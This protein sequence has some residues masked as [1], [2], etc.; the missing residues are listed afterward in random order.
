MQTII[1]KIQELL[2]ENGIPNVDNGASILSQIDIQRAEDNAIMSDEGYEMAQGNFDKI[3][4]RIAPDIVVKVRY[5]ITA[6]GP[7]KY[8]T[9]NLQAIDAYTSEPVAVVSGT[10]GRTMSGILPLMV[11]AAVLD[12]MPDF[13]AVLNDF[14]EE[15]SEYGRKIRFRIETVRNGVLEDG[16]ETEFD[17][18]YLNEIIENWVEENS[19]NGNYS[20]PAS[21]RNR[22]T[23]NDVRI[24]L[25]NEKG[26]AIDARNWVGGLN[27]L[28]KKTYGLK[29]D[30]YPLG[31]GEFQLII[32]KK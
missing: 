2:K 10:S 14:Y 26:R 6:N 19:V 3:R 5:F 15:A 4:E 30:L 8:L 12:R 25:F 7:E 9:F 1:L 31:L 17:G 27:E 11:E 24:P 18:Q 13:V 23:F 16:L 28:L 32:G 21:T 29:T 22:M 20:V